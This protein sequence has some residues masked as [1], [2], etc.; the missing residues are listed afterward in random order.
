[1]SGSERRV[2]L[3]LPCC[4]RSRGRP[5]CGMRRI[6]LTNALTGRIS[7]ARVSNVCLDHGRAA[8]TTFGVRRCLL[9]TIDPPASVPAR[10]TYSATAIG[11]VAEGLSR[12]PSPTSCGRCWTRM[13]RK[14]VLIGDKGLVGYRCTRLPVALSPSLPQLRWVV[15]PTKYRP[16]E[17]DD[18]KGQKNCSCYTGTTVLLRFIALILALF[19]TSAPSSGADGIKATATVS[20]KVP[21]DVL[22]VSF[23]LIERSMP[24]EQ[25]RLRVEELRIREAIE[26]VGA[27]IASWTSRIAVLNAGFS[28]TTFNYINQSNREPAAVDM[29]RDVTARLT[30]L[31][32][33]EP[34]AAVLGRNGIRHA[35]TF[36]WSASTA[37]A[38]RDE[39]VK[40]AAA[41]A[42]A[43]ARALAESV[44]SKAGGVCLSNIQPLDSYRTSRTNRTFGSVR[45]EQ[46]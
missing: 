44:D 30:G 21:A 45:R 32:D 37:D 42:V 40:E 28:T 41:A 34:V 25:S 16:N 2:P 14:I 43:K 13:D 4:V 20:R 3:S 46:A 36:A 22:T 26:K 33:A 9:S 15:D 35:V 7:W 8:R 39:L 31:S 29:R 38:V 27:S 18:V 23:H 11:R 6:G 5:A 12:P 17:I 10:R 1:M 24:E 19:Q